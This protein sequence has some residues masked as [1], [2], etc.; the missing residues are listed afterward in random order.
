MNV[1]NNSNPELSS[2]ALIKSK[3]IKNETLS[4][5]HSDGKHQNDITITQ[6]SYLKICDSITKSKH[7]KE[8]FYDPI[9][10][11]DKQMQCFFSQNINKFIDLSIKININD[12]AIDSSTTNYNIDNRVQSLLHPCFLQFYKPITTTGNGNCLFNMISI[13]L[14][15][16]E[17]L[18]NFLRSASVHTF[19]KYKNEFHDIINTDLEF[20]NIIDISDRMK[21][22]QKKYYKIIHQA[23]KIQF[24]AT[25]II[26]CHWQ[27]FL[28]RAYIFTSNLKIQ[29]IYFS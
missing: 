20:S 11:N 19:L 10:P 9:K 7:Y 21:L 26:Y 23:R 5:N 4:L 16:S 3:I 17:I 15:G 29:I 1:K 2:D 25:N 28:I 27:H 13:C 6:T 12:K 18:S 22:V 14:I 8:I 24:I